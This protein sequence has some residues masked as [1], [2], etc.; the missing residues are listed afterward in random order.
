MQT[1][2]EKTGQTCE[3]LLSVESDGPGSSPLVK[4][5][6]LAAMSLGYGVVQLDVTI[7]NTALNSIGNSIGG[8]V[9]ALQWVVSTYTIAFAALIL[10]A[11]AIGDPIGAK[12]IFVVGFAIFTVASL[13]CALAPTIVVLIAARA[14]QGVGAAVLVPNSLALLNHT[15]RQEKARGRA[16]GI[17]AAGATLALTF[18]PL[19]GGGLIAVA[20]WR[21][22]FLANLPI[23]L[24]GLWLTWRYAAETP[25]A[26]TF[27][28][29]VVRSRHSCRVSCERCI[30]RTDF[31]SQPLFSKVQWLFSAGNRSR[32]CSHDGRCSARKSPGSPGNGE[33]W[34]AGRHRRG[35]NDRCRRLRGVDSDRARHQLLDYVPP[36]RRRR[37]RTRT[38]GSAA[39]IGSPGHSGKSKIWRRLRR[40]ERRPANRQRSRCCSVWIS[41]RQNEHLHARCKRVI[42]Y[43]RAPSGLRLRCDPGLREC[44]RKRKQP[45]FPRF[46]ETS[47]SELFSNGQRPVV[48]SNAKTDIL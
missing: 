42:D 28:T 32:L 2:G 21:T 3:A 38:A 17:W 45:R 10:T 12:R 24:I 34:R 27:Q 40:T 9:S 16:I 43:L 22:I 41:G 48:R 13:V 29:P 8:D 30:L 39:H 15:Y 23:G 36:T 33:I 1:N 25:P 35:R 47:D 26:V 18:G 20:G 14:L 7:V 46:Y 44:A 11:G 31:R 5:L 4:S 6:T 19:A 37:W